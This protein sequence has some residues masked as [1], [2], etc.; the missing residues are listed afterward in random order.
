MRCYCVSAYERE[1]QERESR[2]KAEA[3]QAKINK[4]DKRLDKLHESTRTSIRVSEEIDE[5]N[6]Q[7]NFLVHERLITCPGYLPQINLAQ[8]NNNNNISLFTIIFG[9]IDDI[10][11]ITIIAAL[12]FVLSAFASVILESIWK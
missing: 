12:G 10:F 6:S 11:C 2:E 9:I 8:E 1:K 4:I 7:R 3:I 5:L